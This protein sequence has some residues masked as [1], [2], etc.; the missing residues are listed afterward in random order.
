MRFT[1]F[2]VIALSGV[3]LVGTALGDQL[4][5]PTNGNPLVPGYFAD[6]C[7]R[8]FGD[9]YYLYA[10]PDGWGTGEG[11]PCIWTS[12]DFVNW[13]LHRTNWPE[14]SHKWAPSVTEVN[15]KYYMF[16]S[17]PCQT[18]VG[19]SD[20]PLG[21]WKNALAKGGPL[22]VDQTPAGTITLDAE[23]FR[24][25]DGSFYVPYG[26]WWTPTIQKYKPDLL[27]PDG[28]PIQY[29]NKPGTQTPF[30]LI[31]DCMEAPYI[32]KRNG[33][34]YLMY[35]D[36]FCQNSTYQVKVSTSKSPIGPWTYAAKNPILATNADTSVEGPGHHSMLLERDRH[37][38]VYHRHAKPF[39]DD[40]LHRQI[41]ADVLQ[42][43]PN[44]EMLPIKPTHR[45]VGF[46]AP[47]TKRD[48]NWVV[49][50]GAKV[51]AKASSSAGAAFAPNN[52]ADINNGT[53]W[54][55]SSTAYPQW[56]QVDLGQTRPI[57]RTEID[58]QF[59]QLGYRYF[60]STS[61]DGKNW[62]IFMD[63]AKVS[64]YRYPS[65]EVAKPVNARY[66]KVTIVGDENPNRPNKEIGIWNIKA[67]DGVPKPFT[68]PLV[69][70]GKD[71]TLTT[72]APTIA[73]QG[74]V[75]DLGLPCTARWSVVSGPGKVTLSDPA[76]PETKATFAQPGTYR[77]QL[78]GSNRVGKVSKSITVKVV[79][80]SNGPILS[81][82]FD[83]SEGTRLE[84]G[85]GTNKSGWLASDGD[86]K[87]IPTR[88]TGVQGKALVFEGTRSY[89]SIPALGVYDRFAFAAWV[90]LD[91]VGNAVF[92]A[93]KDNT[94]R[95]NL[96]PEGTL[97]LVLGTDLIV[98]DLP[99]L[100]VGVWSHVAVE[101]DALKGVRFTL[102]G[103]SDKW[104]PLAKPSKIDLRSGVNLGTDQ[105]RYLAGK[106]DSVRLHRSGF[107]PTDLA[108]L[109]KKPN[110]LKVS[111]LKTLPDGREVLLQDL[112]VVFAPRNNRD[113]RST[114]WLYVRNTEDMG[115]GIEVRSGGDD[116]RQGGGVTLRG[117]LDTDRKTGARYVRLTE[118]PEIEAAPQ[119]DAKSVRNFAEAESISDPST[120]LKLTV[121]L[122]SVTPDRG[123]AVVKDGG[124]KTRSISLLGGRLTK[125][126]T[127]GATLEL[128][129][130]RRR[131]TNATAWHAIEFEQI[132]PRVD[133]LEKGILL[134]LTF[135]DLLKGEVRDSFDGDLVAS[136]QRAT[137]TEGQIGKAL[138]LAGQR[139]SVALPDLITT[140]SLT[141]ACW[142][143]PTSL[144]PWQAIF[145]TDQFEPNRK[146]HLTLMEDGRLLVAASGNS[147][148]DIFFKPTFSDSTLSQWRH[149]ALVLDGDN[150][151]LRL[152]MDGAFVEER[153]YAVVYPIALHGGMRLGSWGGNDRFFEG[154]MDDFRLYGRALN[155]AEIAQLGGKRP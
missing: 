33:I 109:S 46:L 45:G 50:P 32:L 61:V 95:F 98:S 113:E 55:A 114:N 139:S 155:D 103:K 135:D 104:R 100:K 129:A 12:K 121:E 16:S 86:V 149:I 40:F 115:A 38:M 42:F 123:A 73:L 6:P 5:H 119:I 79:N 26:T 124:G 96:T 131:E 75:R 93:S 30:G 116:V 94:V 97:R 52:A 84:D 99:R 118:P 68:P 59:P 76:D 105:L 83:E 70:A 65:D 3:T 48:T 72:D 77:L 27:T 9:T 54:K 142:V 148:V 120:P 134:H 4:H 47:S 29:F 60:I 90:K 63:R 49:H 17:V 36:K 151:T 122:V 37:F 78:V 13:T 8:K 14:T 10:T 85:T 44:D 1:P 89:A 67:Y 58:F 106:M 7:I 125:R 28:D 101:V 21:P 11:I 91:R 140:K 74:T 136:V 108:I 143:R 146:L 154:G 150:Q 92:M 25:D 117:R 152:Y 128:Q 22:V 137:L 111:D 102:N 71:A 53:L 15:G 112:A 20:S 153:K 2:A 110:F 138:N 19:V 56:V 62:S 130:V 39:R 23:V 132:S 107:T 66:I 41:A 147:P 133:P 126:T 87:R 57:K 34:Y 82:D 51:T 35:S 18:W 69:D 24:D 141:L 127:L 144:R 43:A 88:G 80:P 145:H 81:Y 31:K 64:A